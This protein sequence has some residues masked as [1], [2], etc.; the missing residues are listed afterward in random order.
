MKFCRRVARQLFFEQKKADKRH[1][2]ELIKGSVHN[3][4]NNSLQKIL[5]SAAGITLLTQPL[6]GASKSTIT[7]IGNQTKIEY[8]NSNKTHTITTTS[9]KGKN[10]FNAFKDFT[11]KSGEIAN[12]QFP[13]NTDNLVNFVKNKI[14]I[15]GTLNAVKNNN[16]D[17]NLFFVSSK[18]FVL[19]KSGVINAGA[20]YSLNRNNS[21]MDKFIKGDKLN[22]NGV[23]DEINS[24]VGSRI[25]NL[26]NQTSV[27]YD[28]PNKTH[29]ITTT[30]IKDRNAFNAFSEFTLISDE[31]A[32]FKFPE[33]TDRILNFVRDKIDIRGTVNAIRDNRIGG[34][35]YF[36]SSEGLILGKGGVINAGAFYAM[37]PT[38]GFME[39]FIGKDSLNLS[40]VDNEIDYIVNRKISNY[41]ERYDYGVT[42]NP[43]GEIIIEGKINTINGIGLY[44]G[45]VN[46]EET[47]SGTKIINN[48]LT[49]GENASLNTFDKNHLS[50]FVN[51]DGINLPQATD[52]VENEGKIEL[53]SVQDNTHQDSKIFEYFGGYTSFSTADAYAKIESD[54]VINS[55]N[56][57]T[58]TAY[59]SNGHVNW[60][61]TD[62]DTGELIKSDFE[63]VANIASITSSVSI[64]GKVFSGI[65]T[66]TGT[67]NIHAISDNQ[68]ELKTVNFCALGLEILGT[69]TPFN[70]DANVLKSSASSNVNIK[71]NATIEAQKYISI[72]AKTNSS[73]VA[74][75]CTSKF[76]TN[77]AASSN[78]SLL[79]IISSAVNIQ[80]ASSK[81]SF[82]GTAISHLDKEDE[83]KEGNKV[84]DTK[85][86]ISILSE[87]NSSLG[88]NSKSKSMNTQAWGGAAV[89]V[90]KNKNT[91]V[92]NIGQNADFDAKRSI[93]LT[94]VTN[95][96][97]SVTAECELRKTGYAVPVV[98]VSLFDSDATANV[99]GNINAK[100]QEGTFTINVNNNINSDELCADSG[101]Q[102]SPWEWEKFA[103]D[104]KKESID[105][106]FET[107]H[108]GSFVS[109]A[110][111]NQSA[112]KFGIAAAVA[113]GSGKHNSSLNIKPGALIN[114]AGSLELSS[115]T[116]VNDVKYDSTA[117]IYCCEDHQGSKFQSSIAF[118]Y[119]NFDYTSN[120]IIDDSVNPNTSI[121]GK[122][123]SIESEVYQPYRR[124][125][126]MWEEVEAAWEKVKDY[127]HGS[128]HAD[129]VKR[130]GDS[131]KKLN[132]LVVDPSKLG[133]EGNNQQAAQVWRE[134][135]DAFDSLLNF[136]EKEGVLTQDSLV[137]RFITS[138][139][140]L[141]EFTDYSNFLNYSV[142]SSVNT[143]E[144]GENQP[145]SISGSIYYG[146]N[147]SKSNILIGKKAVINA[148]D[149]CGIS[150]KSTSDVTSTVMLGGPPILYH[151]NQGKNAAGGSVLVHNNN[152]EANFLAASGATIGS[153][154]IDNL[155]IITMNNFTPIDLIM[156]TSSITNGFNGMLSVVVGKSHSNL[157]IDDGTNLGGKKLNLY[158]YNNT[159]A[160][161]IVGA[162]TISEKKGVGVGLAVTVLDKENQILV[163]DNDK[164]WQELRKKLGLRADDPDTSEYVYEPA[165]FSADIFNAVAKTTGTINTIGVAGGVAVDDKS[166]YDKFTTN[167]NRITDAIS[168]SG[169]DAGVNIATY[170]A[171]GK[172]LDLLPS[173]RNVPG[174]A[175]GAPDPDPD[176]EREEAENE[177]YDNDGGVPQQQP[178]AANADLSL[179]FNGSAAA[180]SIKNYTK[181]I[182]E[183]TNVEFFNDAAS[184]TFNASAINSA[185][186]LSFSGAAG[187]MA[188][189]G[190][191]TGVSVGLDGSVAVNKIN[192]TTETLI[193]KT[194]IREA[195]QLNAISI[196]GGESIAAGL[197][198]QVIAASHNPDKSGS[199]AV[200]A[201]INLI[202]NTV[203]A[204]VKDSKSTSSKSSNSTNMVVTAYES[205]TQ[206]T[207]GVSAA[208]GKQKG[209]VGVSIDISKIKNTLSSEINGGT[210]EKMKNVEVNALQASTIVNAGIAVAVAAG[211]NHDSF[212]VSGSGVYSNLKNTS[213]ANIKNATISGDSVAIRAQDVRTSD[214]GVTT[215]EDNLVRNGKNLDFIE[216]DGK[217]FYTNLETATGTTELGDQT[218]KRKGSLLVTASISG[219]YSGTAVGLGAAINQIVNSY[220]INVEG[221]TITSKKFD[222]NAISYTNAITVGAG[223]AVSSERN[224][225][226]GFGSA[227]WN[228]IANTANVTFTNN[229]IKSDSLN[230]KTLND[231]TLVGVGG[232]ISIG[233]KGTA[234]VGA[235]VAYNGINNSANSLIYGGSVTGVSSDTSSL[236]VNAENSSRIWGI[237][238]SVAASEKVAVAG[239]VSVNEIE[240][241]ATASVGSSTAGLTN[242][243][244]LKLFEVI[245]TDSANIKSL[246]GA[247]TGSGKVSIGG[248]VTVNHI[249]GSTESILDKVKFF[250]NESNIRA[251][252]ESNN[253]SL[254]AGL[255]GSGSF[256][257][258]GAAVNNDVFRD[259]KTSISNSTTDNAS[260]TFNTSATAIGNTGSLAAAVCGAKDASAGAGI[261]VNRMGG[262]V[263][264]TLKGNNFKVKD[265][266]AKAYSNQEITTIG[267]A[268]SGGGL[269]LSGSIAYNSIAYNTIAEAI[270]NILLSAENNIAIKA[271]SDDILK[272]YA[273][274]LN[275]G[276]G[277]PS[278]GGG[279][280]AGDDQ[281]D[282]AGLDDQDDDNNPIA[283]NAADNRSR[284]RKMFDG[285][286]SALKSGNGK[287][288]SVSGKM[289]G[290]GFG[291]SV[292]VNEIDGKTNA[293]LSGGKIEALGKN[294]SEQVTLNNIIKDSD[295][296]H[297]YV[298]SSTICIN[299][300]LAGKRETEKR[301]GLV[302][303]S[304]STHTT[305]SF[306]ASIGVSG[307]AA[308]N[309]NVNVNYVGGETNATFDNATVNDKKDGKTAGNISV[310]AT[311][312]TNTAG[313]VGNV[314]LGGK[315]GIGLS[316]DT[317]KVV[318]TINAKVSDI[319][320]GSVADNLEVKAISK[321][322]ISS[323]VAGLAASLQVGVA[324]NIDVALLDSTTKAL[325]ENSKISVNS[326]DVEANHYARAHE[327]AVA[328]GIGAG[329]AGVG[330]AVVVNNDINTVYA[331]VGS[332]TINA[333]SGSNG[334]FKVNS[335][336]DDDFETVTGAGGAG[337]YAGV[338]GAVAVDYMENNVETNVATS[339]FGNVDNRAG[340]VEI[341][342]KDVS[343]QVSKGGS[344]GIGG[345]AGVSLT[346]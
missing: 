238:L 76:V 102:S 282:A 15:E 75:A 116:Y 261:S 173:N 96:D 33:N 191:G 2:K 311:D 214:K 126:A 186:T 258:D 7:N 328:A 153:N 278:G 155:D 333:N 315:A 189:G 55:R 20:Y 21:F 88:V 80:E 237:A 3:L 57:V 271:V 281:N 97:N 60:I 90:G 84:V 128:E 172:L 344:V 143:I 297:K 335:I 69:L 242:I 206:V 269:S 148:S 225:G 28:K 181:V 233:I 324:G 207:G 113:Y 228:S 41:N 112:S 30:A 91:A 19:G 224:K 239:T 124:P 227:A 68:N 304:S 213:T 8:N 289:G 342:S 133:S 246:S 22:I 152:S 202:N 129:T 177:D 303:D 180:N 72:A 211:V 310:K 337:M 268:G 127:F 286:S 64:G 245:A 338:A 197:G 47:A 145:F 81:V 220:N 184:A 66:A 188:Q 4:L 218:S 165:T 221:S 287:M 339:T 270:D 247:V 154:E 266:S 321:Q 302:V 101:L 198:L 170:W 58:I 244:S 85:K 46:K 250:A 241:N 59:A 240:N 290:V 53:V 63:K 98:A 183:N 38:K 167:I 330:A 103:S 176:V 185:H 249:N 166:K 307:K 209:A 171:L 292:S 23:D 42:I 169:I 192:N 296:N 135:T 291:V 139:K 24:I 230:L 263:K 299:S 123:V 216:K 285:Y 93:N 130:V 77:K 99:Q 122:E 78:L 40:R 252:S 56:D 283:P 117:N 1:I 272:N 17:G 323:V 318:R 144:T 10:A 298:D 217:A 219:A 212:A 208:V 264:T 275:I 294:S 267:I 223:A 29:T 136:I 293:T 5:L 320:E 345:Y 120:V 146:N 150:I 83:I 162:L 131:F 280:A 174:G 253:L 18:G 199:G 193:N 111:P 67:I 125:Q 236:I 175:P 109:N 215:Y 25:L 326:L 138:A 327:L 260:A 273:G 140:K 204:N 92:L 317:N 141:F 89:S 13:T 284:F 160:D 82:D 70:I 164:E 325:V 254:A 100:S 277:I 248:A 71:S 222:A 37:T 114:T 226:S 255:G 16:H 51:L 49:I 118:L 12:L 340:S 156:G 201:S 190:N 119:N 104:V 314:S 32:I 27:N 36:L 6:F 161:N 251:Y 346:V 26:G 149:S 203:K 74:G 151:N 262:D 274:M 43:Y 316:A 158:S 31:I 332:S 343:K 319:K 279:G 115:L 322:G 142:S 179:T 105:K 54:G 234:A 232:A 34:D 312:Y 187:I 110:I 168:V 35:L 210:Y 62:E 259:V 276:I 305:K 243:S 121:I 79:P 86:S 313:F 157:K 65:G 137:G 134:I 107:L 94:S 182:I 95:S 73:S 308:A 61:K 205:D 334:A 200:N 331:G 235:S 336:N 257:F 300:S 44:A 301:T 87:S 309:A 195:N 288:G 163:Q 14:D 132:T 11:L 39:K 295:I 178:G 159:N 256:A 196:D 231:S 229:T 265:L 52:I 45:G 341:K 329:T 306:L 194:N 50:S 108:L 48:G 106:L 9:I 147:S